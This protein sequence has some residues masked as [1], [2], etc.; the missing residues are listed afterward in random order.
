MEIIKGLNI[1]IRFVLELSLLFVLAFSSYHVIENAFLRWFFALSLPLVVAS[2]WGYFIAP[3]SQ[4]VLSMP[5]R[6]MLVVAFFSLA[7]LLLTKIGQGRLAVCLII[8]FAV[9][10]MLIIIWRQ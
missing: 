9:N 3:K 1:G 10:E 8:I 6:S 5:W 2:L 4:H 7:A